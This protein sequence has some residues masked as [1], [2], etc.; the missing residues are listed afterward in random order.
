MKT[1]PFQHNRAA[2]DRRKDRWTAPVDRETVAQA[3][4]GVISLLL[5]PTKPVPRGWF[6]ELKGAKVLCLA[7]AGGQQAPVLA[8]AGAEVVSFDASPEQL[9]R[10]REVALREGLDIRREEGDMRDLS[11]FQDGAF[12]LVFH[13]CSNCFVPDPRPVWAQA[14][15]VLRPGG[16]LLAGFC[17]PVLWLVDPEKDAKGVVDVRY[18][19]PFSDEEQLPPETVE[20]MKKNLEPLSFGH[21]L[22][23]QLAGQTDAGLAVAGFYE[24]GWEPGVSAL[25]DRIALFGATRS[26]KLALEGR[27]SPGA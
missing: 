19:V 10:D 11:R 3:R 15:R 13:P 5:T 25:G 2:W 23:A 12:D 4:R 1:D 6:G 18:R 26:L 8:A 27:S 9:A 14:A 21:T 17:L 20:R 24:D 16:A 7:S 22:E